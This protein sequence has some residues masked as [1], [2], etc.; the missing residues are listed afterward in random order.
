MVKT[1]GGRIDVRGRPRGRGK[2]R[3][4]SVETDRMDL[5]EREESVG[6]NRPRELSPST[7]YVGNEGNDIRRIDTRSERGSSISNAPVLNFNIPRRACNAQL[8]SN[9]LLKNTL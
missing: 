8:F 3:S 6:K 2:G 4:R 5:L 9:F 1:R 7:A